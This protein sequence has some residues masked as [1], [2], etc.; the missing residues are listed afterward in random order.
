MKMSDYRLFKSKM[1]APEHQCEAVTLALAVN[2]LECDYLGVLVSAQIEPEDFIDPALGAIYRTCV[3]L[4]REK[5]SFDFNQL[6]LKLDPRFHQHYYELLDGPVTLNFDFFVEELQTKKVA[7]TTYRKMLEYSHMFQNPESIDHVTNAVDDIQSTTYDVA[8][9]S[10]LSQTVPS[11]VKQ[12]VTSSLESLEKRIIEYRETGF[13]GVPTGL[14]QLDESLGGGWQKGTY[15]ILAARTSTG[16]TMFGVNF[17]NFAALAGFNVLY[18]SIE[19]N[20]D[21]IM[22]RLITAWSE[23]EVSKIQSGN[24]S[25]AEIDR[26]HR[27]VSNLVQADK[28][29]IMHLERGSLE[30]FE[31]HSKRLKK[32]K[33][34]DLIV[35]DYLQDAKIHSQKFK[36][37]Y[38]HV[39]EISKRVR[40]LCQGLEVPILALAQLNRDACEKAELRPA[41]HHIRD[42]GQIEQDADNI[43]IIHQ[44]KINEGGIVNDAWWLILDKA[45]DGQKRDIRVYPNFKKQRIE[46]IK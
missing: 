13:S 42:S 29:S 39:T 3:A 9:R 27:G 32:M 4:Y 45:R 6:H 40:D 21:R 2:N 25:E 14:K 33:Q 10:H 19:M 35:L 1:F 7:R 31:M 22:N 43:L 5:G 24:L 12:L 16:K 15:N 37:A 41:K 17:S 26:I 46:G 36:S 20:K 38:E 23:V 11:T 34:L 8:S 44:A 30:A 18:A 28:L